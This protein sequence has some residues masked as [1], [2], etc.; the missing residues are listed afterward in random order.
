M[1]VS[2]I[3]PVYNVGDYIEDCLRSVIRQVYSGDIE[4]IIVDD[5][6]TDNSIALAERL[7]ASYK[8]PIQF[9]I[10]HHQHNRGLSAARN[11]GID[12]AQGDYIFFLDS[13]DEL[14]DD[15]IATLTKPLET[16]RYDVVLGFVTYRS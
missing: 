16:E 14:T 7:M 5:C 3:I 12:V 1:K 8:G 10:L 11:T 2:I 4:C 6:G 9:I 15:S 13:D